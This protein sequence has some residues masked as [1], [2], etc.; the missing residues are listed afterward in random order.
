[1]T[2]KGDKFGEG[3]ILFEPILAPRETFFLSFFYLISGLRPPSAKAQI[4]VFAKFTGDREGCSP[5]FFPFLHP[6]K[7]MYSAIYFL[8]MLCSCKEK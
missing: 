8:G 2:A 4:S 1:M 5:S 3:T 7:K 6:E